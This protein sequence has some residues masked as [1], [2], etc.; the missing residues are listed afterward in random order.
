MVPETNVDVSCFHK[1]TVADACV[2][3]FPSEMECVLFHGGKIAHPAN[4]ICLYY[5]PVFNSSP[6]D[7]I[8]AIL[9]DEISKRTLLNEKLL[10]EIVLKGP[11][12]NNSALVQIM[13]CCLFGTKSLSEPML[14]RF[15]DAYM[16]HEG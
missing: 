9:A 12:D 16:R 10:I 8:A 5:V 14:T 15:A 4:A 6:L 7:K 13:P 11:I 3:V 1:P 2:C